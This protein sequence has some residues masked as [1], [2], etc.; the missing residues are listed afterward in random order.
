M[1]SKMNTFTITLTEADLQ[2][3]NAGLQE[4]PMRIAA[5][6][7]VKINGQ[8]QTAMQPKSAPASQ[9]CEVPD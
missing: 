5:P 2:V 9:Q 6:L 1:D 3:I 4:L 7:V 8:L